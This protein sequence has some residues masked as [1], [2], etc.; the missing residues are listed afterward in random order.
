MGLWR[1]AGGQEVGFGERFPRQFTPLG[2][3]FFGED[4][5]DLPHLGYS[6]APANPRAAMARRFNSE[7]V[8]RD[9]GASEYLSPGHA[10]AARSYSR[11]TIIVVCLVLSA[12]SDI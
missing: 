5:Q 4:L 6:E 8:A 2:D 9:A 1:R 7:T 12:L 11:C 3:L 10:P